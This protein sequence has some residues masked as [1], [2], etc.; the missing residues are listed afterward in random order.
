VRAIASDAA[1]GTSRLGGRGTH[2]PRCRA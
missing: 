2:W 1:V